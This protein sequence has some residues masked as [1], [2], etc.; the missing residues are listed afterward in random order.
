[1]NKPILPLKTRVYNEFV[2]ESQRWDRFEPRDDDI[3]ICTPAKCGTT[4]TQMICALLIFQKTKFDKAL[5]E[6]SPW[7]DALTAPCEQV[8][9]QL[10]AQTHRRF[11]KTHTPLD[12][13]PYFEQAK[14]ICV[15]RDPRDAFLSLT[16]HSQNMKREIMELLQKNATGEWRPPNIPPEDQIEWFCDWIT[17]SCSEEPNHEFHSD[18]L[19]YVRS[20]WQY[21][22]LPNILM[23][24][25][26]D[27]KA[28][29]DGEMRRI[30]KFLDIQIDETLWPELVSAASFE[31]M[32]NNADQLAPQVTDNVWKDTGQFF[33]KGVSGQWCK[34][35]NDKALDLYR[36]A[37]DK[38]LESDL[39]A[40]LEQGRLG[41]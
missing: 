17:S 36:Q 18:V 39:S 31:N 32:K 3:I 13:L 41:G 2:L 33:N 9:D 38:N 37:M 4:W 40:W 29:L 12:G 10:Q 7:L 5:T 34:V 20:F 1:M 6:H 25:Y 35:L 23:L 24:H 27:L 8:L 11:I 26:S 15:G 30:A 28:D 16:N 14:Y 21:R 22:H 19:Y